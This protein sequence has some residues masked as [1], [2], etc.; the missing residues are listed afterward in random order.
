MR[1]DLGIELKNVHHFFPR[2]FCL[3]YIDINNVNKFK[4]W[5]NL[6][7]EQLTGEKGL[8]RERQFC[9]NLT[10]YLTRCI[11]TTGW[12]NTCGLVCLHYICMLKHCVND[13]SKYYSYIWLHTK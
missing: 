9:I 12:F 4:L 11:T 3:F 13:F 10:F 6:A 2:F 7:V 5:K 1:S 8:L